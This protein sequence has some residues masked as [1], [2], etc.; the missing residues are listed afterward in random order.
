[1]MQSKSQQVR[2]AGFTLVELLV[3]IAIIGI[4]IALLL[5]AVQSARE[6]A[7]RTQCRNHLKQ[8]ALGC[9]LHEDAHGFFPSGGWGLD[10]TADPDQGYGPDQPGSWAYNILEFIEAGDIHDLGKGKTGNAATWRNDSIAL[11]QSI[12][13]TFLCPTR[14]AAQLYRSRWNTVRVQTWLGGTSGTAQT[15]GVVKGD[16]AANS[17]DSI[18]HSGDLLWRPNSYAGLDSPM[19]TD[20]NSENS[21]YFQT[22]VMHY[23]SEIT[24]SKIVDGTTKT[25]LVGEK[26]LDPDRYEFSGDASFTFGDNQCLWTGFEW[27]NHRHAWNPSPTYRLDPELFQP[28]QDTPGDDNIDAFGS[29]HSGGLNMAFCDGSVQFQNY[30]IDKVAHR[31]LANR[32]D[33]DEPVP[34]PRPPRP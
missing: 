17:G 26:Y 29:A 13:D 33:G 27:D 6:S 21:R 22:G 16:Y 30:D 1:M 15:Q 11:H 32:L 18:E 9:L 3:V 20:T 19:W 4:L 10:W 12:V 23:R 34:E 5:P 31:R 24:F 14:R 25:Y 28:R 2:S 7:R 8:I